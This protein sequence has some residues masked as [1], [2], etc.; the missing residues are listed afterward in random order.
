MARAVQGYKSPTASRESP[1]QPQV[2]GA[3]LG[4]KMLRPGFL[5]TVAFRGVVV[6]VAVGFVVKVV[7]ELLKDRLISWANHYLD[8][9]FEAPVRAFILDALS[10]PW[11][12]PVTIATL[13]VSGIVLHAYLTS[14]RGPKAGQKETGRS[15]SSPSAAQADA[16]DSIPISIQELRLRVID[17][18]AGFFS[19]ENPDDAQIINLGDVTIANISKDR[20]VALELVLRITGRTTN[21]PL[22]ADLRGPRGLLL[23]KDDLPAKWARTKKLEVIEYFRNPVEIEP[24]QVQKKRLAFLFTA[25]RAAFA[26]IVA[27]PRGYTYALEVI[28]HMSGNAISIPIRGRYRGEP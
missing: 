23:G 4:G 28:D 25:G 14:R 9:Q 10:S 16:K 11:M 20:R 7:W 12:V 2:A 5:H 22:Q 13:V 26:P 27:N 1:P 24:Q 6:S 19:G 3:D 18:H 21:L 8:E 17:G 15:A